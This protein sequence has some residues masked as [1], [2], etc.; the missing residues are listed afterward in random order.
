MGKRTLRTIL[1]AVLVAVLAAPCGAEAAMLGKVDGQ[2]VYYSASET[3]RVADSFIYIGTFSSEV[4]GMSRSGLRFARAVYT[5]FVFGKRYNDTNELVEIFI[6]RWEELPSGWRL[7][8]PGQIPEYYYNFKVTRFTGL[9]EFLNEKGF[10]FSSVFY[11]GRMKGYVRD[12]T[13]VQHYFAKATTVMPQDADK[14][15]QVRQSYYQAIVLE[16]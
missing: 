16:H 1:L 11:G 7:P 9:R 3:Y 14:T 12:G 5:N 6:T 10:T 15:E 4:D 13:S 8:N 2:R